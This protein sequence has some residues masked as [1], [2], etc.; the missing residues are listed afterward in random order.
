MGRLPHLLDPSAYF[1]E[2]WH[3][4]ERQALFSTWHL[5]GATPELAR[6]GA[7]LTTSLL[8]RE[9]QV[10]NF[11]GKI[12]AVS[13]V[14]THRHCLLR[15][16]KSG[17]DA[18]LVCPY[19]GW[20]FGLDG[21][22]REIPD[23]KNFAPIDREALSLPLYRVALCGQLMFVCLDPR[24]PGLNEQLGS[25]FP[26]VEER[27]GESWR[28]TLCLEFPAPANWKVPVENSLEAYHVPRVHPHTLRDDPGEDRSLYEIEAG[29]TAFSTTHFRSK[30]A[31]DRGLHLLE[32]LL[33]RGLGK[34]QQ[35]RYFH[36]HV[37]PNLLFSFTDTL[38][39]VQ[40]VVPTG[41]TTSRSTVRQ[42]APRSGPFGLP[43]RIWGFFG[44]RV[45]LRILSEDRILF[46]SIQRGLE[47]SP[48]A[49]VLGYVERRIHAF[50]AHMREIC[51]RPS[52]V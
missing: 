45:T 41:P 17:V 51:G 39:L 7:F 8:G 16:Q 52:E 4:R 50:Q 44:A 6:P 24:A 35:G 15:H 3:E 38:S 40:C 11:D 42:F 28:K 5:V 1:T 33:L 9:V 26:I 21:R 20:E 29:R 23:P 46:P 47:A 27:F 12:V 36:H 18:R 30:S 13:N 32:R 37:F 25:F 34:E 31:V 2:T 19:H 10:R 43:M 14:C 48:H 22:T 49:G